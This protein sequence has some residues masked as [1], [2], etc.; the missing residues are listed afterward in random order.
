MCAGA[1]LGA[2]GE[3]VVTAAHCL[4]HHTPGTDLYL[5][6]GSHDPERAVF[7]T[8]E[9]YVIHPDF[10]A[11]SLRND[12]AVIKIGE[13]VGGLGGGSYDDGEGGDVGSDGSGGGSDGTEEHSQQQ[14]QQR[15]D[16]QVAKGV[17]GGGAQGR[18]QGRR[19]LR[20]AAGVTR[21]PQGATVEEPLLEALPL[22]DVELPEGFD[23]G[24]TPVVTRGPPP[25]PPPT[26]QQTRAPTSPPTAREVLERPPPP[27][28][29]LPLPPPPPPL[30]PMEAA[31]PIDLLRGDPPVG[32]ALFV[33]GWGRLCDAIANATC[34]ALESIVPTVLQY[35]TVKMLAP[36]GDPN[37]T[38][39][40]YVPYAAAPVAGELVQEQAFAT[41][42]PTTY[43]DYS[44]DYYYD[45]D[46]E[47]GSDG[48]SETAGDGEFDPSTMLCVGCPDGGRDACQGDSGGPVVAVGADGRPHLVGLVSFGRSCATAEYPGVYTWL[49][50]Y[51][52][53][54]EEVTNQTKLA[55][56]GFGEC[57]LALTDSCSGQE[58]P[59]PPW[60]HATQLATAC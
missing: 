31:A 23:G 35:A 15:Q 57:S 43:Y 51:E 7:A 11:G 38:C 3:W 20:Q 44:Y 55:T 41:P 54:L 56:V 49:S 12:V 27:P 24:I 16:P 19:M 13:L 52:G 25:P 8:A 21:A 50:R 5:R 4:Q 45:Y 17:W 14:E 46:N 53:W 18:L 33:A 36:A 60:P 9:R 28:P 32:A 22:L 30:K 37:A 29:P 2:S 34:A 6:Y 42:S 48:S 1:L 39:G 40:D 47:S 59:P 58:P 10:D 26:P